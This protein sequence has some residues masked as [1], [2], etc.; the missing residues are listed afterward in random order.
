M[1]N[2]DAAIHRHVCKTIEAPGRQIRR[3]RQINPKN[4]RDDPG[5]TF[6]LATVQNLLRDVKCVVNAFVKIVR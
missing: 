5:A 4:H 1:E 2:Q 6:V 3:N